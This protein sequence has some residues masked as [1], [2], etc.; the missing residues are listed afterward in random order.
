MGSSQT[1][2]IPLNISLNTYFNSV[3]TTPTSQTTNTKS[4][5]D[6]ILDEIELRAGQLEC[7][8]TWISDNSLLI[9][10]TEPTLGCW[11]I[12]LFAQFL[13]ER[14]TG[15]PMDWESSGGM[16]SLNTPHLFTLVAKSYLSMKRL[17]VDQTI[18]IR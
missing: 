1:Q 16:L 10:G 14:T 18:I 13:A 5:I 17:G 4:L 7:P 6:Q 15:N 11:N 2:Q 12:E 8:F 9:L 3:G